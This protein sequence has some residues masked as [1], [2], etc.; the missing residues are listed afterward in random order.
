M[1]GLTLAPAV[2][3]FAVIFA[4]AKADLASFAWGD[5]LM[6]GGFIVLLGWLSLPRRDKPAAHQETSQGI[7]FRLGKAL[8]RVWRGD[9]RGA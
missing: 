4:L 3:A 8:N 6:M 5:W 2:F 9:R 7:A 1:A